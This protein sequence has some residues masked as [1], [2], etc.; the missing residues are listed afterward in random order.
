MELKRIVARDLRAV[1]PR[2]GRVWLVV[3]YAGQLVATSEVR[4]VVG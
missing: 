3:R 2:D 1:F 4:L